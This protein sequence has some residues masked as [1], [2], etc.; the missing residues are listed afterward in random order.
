MPMRWRC[1]PENS[2]GNRFACSGFKPTSAIRSFTRSTLVA[3]RDAV[4][5]HRLADDRAHGHARVERR[6]RI[7]EHDLDL[8]AQR[9]QL[10]R[11]LGR[12]LV[13]AEL[14]RT[15]CRIEE[16]EHQSP[17][18]GLAATRLA[19]EAERL[20]LLDREAEP[21][22]RL[23][24]ADAPA[25]RGRHRIGNSFTRSRDLEHAALASSA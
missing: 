8:A 2:C 16:L 25:E 24:R 9:A 21:R 22:H 17:G 19:D 18:R 20:A 13:P 7:L 12:E 15:R 23:D 11:L 5:P 10:R 3:R 1:P 4:D 14:H 6:V